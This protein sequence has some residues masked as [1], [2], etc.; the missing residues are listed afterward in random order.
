MQTIKQDTQPFIFA[1]YVDL[2]FIIDS[3]L[4]F[5]LLR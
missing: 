4:T 1:F 3:V 5:A 2:L